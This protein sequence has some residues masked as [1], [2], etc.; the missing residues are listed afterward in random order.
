MGRHSA[1]VKWLDWWTLSS[2]MAMVFE[3]VNG[4]WLFVAIL[5]SVKSHV[6][7]LQT[8]NS[9]ALVVILCQTVAIFCLVF[10]QSFSWFLARLAELL[11][12]P[13]KSSR[14][15]DHN[16]CME[17]KWSDICRWIGMYKLT[18][19]CIELWLVKLISDSSNTCHAVWCVEY[20]IELWCNRGLRL[21][22]FRHFV[23]LQ[24]FL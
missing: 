12:Q 3:L 8:G 21:W 24:M 5:F 23:N 15:A 13:V 2:E 14:S 11:V 20:D 16:V 9:I 6:A 18:Q 22:S 19:W 1:L 4:S 7:V 10:L 17:M